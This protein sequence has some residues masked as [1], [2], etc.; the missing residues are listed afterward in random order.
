MQG[1]EDLMPD[2]VPQSLVEEGLIFHFSMAQMRP[3]SIAWKKEAAIEVIETLAEHAYAILGGDVLALRGEQL[4]YTGDYWDLPD[5]DVVLWEEY[6]E[7]TRERSIDF[8]EDISRRK[9]EMFV[10][11]IF[12]IGERD[13]RKQMRDFGNIKY[14]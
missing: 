10:Y 12:F 7:R 8:I 4:D 11:T 5:E 2:C 6:V 3:D 9:G 14:R 13:Y 1:R